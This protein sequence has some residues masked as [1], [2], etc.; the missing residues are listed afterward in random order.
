MQRSLVDAITERLRADILSG[1]IRP[2]ERLRSRQLEEQL[3]VSH[4]PIREAL[5]RLEGEGL[6]QNIPQRGA[7][8]TLIS[9]EELPDLYVLRK[10]VESHAAQRAL[11]LLPERAAEATGLL[12]QLAAMPE[13]WM[14]PKYAELHTRFHWLTIEQGATPTMAHVIRHLRQTTERHL[15]QFRG[16][17][18]FAAKDHRRILAAA[19]GGNGEELANAIVAHLEHSERVVGDMLGRRD[20][21][22]SSGAQ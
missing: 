22:K 8:V 12:E 16:A 3:E 20:S 13:E 17:L 4:I 1:R 10:F 21:K 11:P 14:S 2:G 15:A 19:K 18:P 9:L 5:R 6:V 7:V